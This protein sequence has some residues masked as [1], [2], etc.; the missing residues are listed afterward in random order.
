MALSIKFIVVSIKFQQ[1]RNLIKPQIETIL[2]QLSLP[3]FCSSQRDVKTFQEDPIEYVRM[4]ADNTNE[5]YVKKQLSFLV[6]KMCSLRFGQRKD[7]NPPMHLMKYIENI[8]RNL[9]Q[10]QG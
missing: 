2:F 3:L 8:E 9:G 6:E 10:A 4:T 5:F 1:T 7:K